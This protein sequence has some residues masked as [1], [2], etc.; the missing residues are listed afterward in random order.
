MTA[1]LSLAFA[2][3]QELVESKAMLNALTIDVEEY[4]HVTNLETCV[5]PSQWEHME[6]RVEASTHHLLD[7]LAE[8]GVRATFFVL[9]WVAERQRSLVRRIKVEGHEIGSHG[10]AHQRLHHLSPDEFRQDLLRSRR[11]LEDIVGKAVTI[12]RAPSF[13]IVP[14]TLW[15]LDVLIEEGYVL[16]SSIYPTRHDRY[17]IPGAPMEPHRIEREVGHIWEF[18]PPV[19]RFL[20]CALPVGGGGYFRLYPY[21]LTRSALKG[22]NASGRPFAFYLH[23]WELDPE[24]PRLRPG[25]LRGFRHYVNL[26]RTEDRLRRLLEDFAFGTISQ[27]MDRLTGEAPLPTHSFTRAA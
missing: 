12:Y 7:L 21:A 24:Q 2:Q 3:T 18:P 23:P 1:T 25:W 6:S 5:R 10:Y 16:D 17:G 11:V 8:T 15:A 14:R 9:G 27:A 20:G 22:I 19:C 26:H 4:F 13:S